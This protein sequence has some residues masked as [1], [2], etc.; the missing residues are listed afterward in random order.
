MGFATS[1]MANAIWPVRRERS[2]LAAAFGTYP[3]R[4]AASVTRSYTSGVVLIP[5]SARDAEA[6]ETFASFATVVMVGRFSD[7]M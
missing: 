6:T 1:G 3:T 7:T 4:S 2:E 5:F